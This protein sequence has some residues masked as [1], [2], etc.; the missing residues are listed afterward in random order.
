MHALSKMKCYL[1]LFGIIL[2]NFLV[3]Q[4]YIVINGDDTVYC[5]I[6]SVGT[7]KIFFSVPTDSVPYNSSLLLSKVNSYYF[8]HSSELQDTIATVEKSKKVRIKIARKS[9]PLFRFSASC[10]LGYFDYQ[11]T[12]ENAYTK[13]LKSGYNAAFE[14]HYFPE[15]LIMD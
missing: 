7:Q 13:E 11:N 1:L 14:A 3:A 5:K 6:E 2:S 12:K 15:G 9:A 10:G 8:N 4:D